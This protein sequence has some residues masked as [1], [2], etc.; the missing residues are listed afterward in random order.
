MDLNTDVLIVTVTKVE[1]LAVIRAFSK[2]A[3]RKP[4][5]IRIGD[6]MYNDLGVT[7][8]TRICMVQSAM[9][10]GGGGAAL[11]AVQKGIDAVS[12]AAVIMAGIAFG[13][14]EEKQAKAAENRD[15]HRPEIVLYPVKKCI[16]PG[17]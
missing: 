1:S 14:D 8:D 10:A 6:R 11:Q 17:V 5:T 13:V 15:D 4:E 2:A 3:G 9:G 16:E 7:N 12:P